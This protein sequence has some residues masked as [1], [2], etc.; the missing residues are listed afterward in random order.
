MVQKITITRD[1]AELLVDLLEDNY[2][3]AR[4]SHAGQGADLAVQIR[5]LFGMGP[6][7]DLVYGVFKK[8]S[9]LRVHS[10]KIPVSEWQEEEGSS[11]AS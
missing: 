9:Q 7:T 3:A 4:Y 11:D 6:Q 1:E 2:R 10:C 8:L 5:E